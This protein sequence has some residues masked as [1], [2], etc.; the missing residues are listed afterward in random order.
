VVVVFVILL[1][2]C[3]KMLY[4]FCTSVDFSRFG[5]GTLLIFYNPA[6]TRARLADE[7]GELREAEWASEARAGREQ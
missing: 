7:V 4:K 5:C 6:S 2:T 3:K 1:Y